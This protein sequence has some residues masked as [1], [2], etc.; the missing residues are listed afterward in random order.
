MAGTV[1]SSKNLVDGI[2]PSSNNLVDG[3]PTKMAKFKIKIQPQA[4]QL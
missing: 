1:L 2:V 4:R 3:T